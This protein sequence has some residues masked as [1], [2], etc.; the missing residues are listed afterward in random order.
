MLDSPAP[1]GMPGGM[2]FDRWL[3]SVGRSRETGWRWRQAGM[4]MPVNIQGQWY[5]TSDEDRR[6]WE[7]AKAGEFAKEIISVKDKVQ[8]EKERAA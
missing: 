8:K 5:I 4:V 2:T 3:E 6:F 7:R 1:A